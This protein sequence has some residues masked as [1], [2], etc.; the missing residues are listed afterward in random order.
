VPYVTDL[1]VLDMKGLT[2]REVARSVPRERS[3]ERMMAHD[4]SLEWSDAVARKVDLMAVD[5]S[6]LLA[7]TS[8]A[9]LT[10]VREA[11]G[12]PDSIW[13]ADV[14][15]G[16]YLVARLPRG[17]QITARRIPRLRF[18]SLASP[19]FLSSFVTRAI[20]AWSDS[21]VASPSDRRARLRLAW[22]LLAHEDYE[23]ARRHYR[24]AV[25]SFPNDLEAWDGLSWCEIRLGHLEEARAALSRAIDLARAQ[26]E[27]G[28]LGDLEARASTLT[29]PAR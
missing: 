14:G 9:M 19:R 6:P 22:L 8:D 11:F 1:R 3:G 4:R 7:L 5:A 16:L 21:L 13:A 28:H 23:A 25:E 26:G 10:H 18:E 2:D 24:V 15:D 12:S 20:A 27:T 29:K 17:A